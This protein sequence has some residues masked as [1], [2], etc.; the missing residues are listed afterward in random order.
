[1]SAPSPNNRIR[2]RA[3]RVAAR[4][5]YDNLIEKT[6]RALYED[7]GFKKAGLVLVAALFVSIICCAWDVP[8]P[9]KLGVRNE[10]NIVC[11]TPFRVHSPDLTQAERNEVR[12]KTLPYYVNDP[13]KLDDYEGELINGLA[14]VLEESDFSNCSEGS[15]KFL[16]GFLSPKSPENALA[17][18]FEVLRSYFA[19]DEGLLQFRATLEEAFKPYREKGVL[20]SLRT[21][22]DVDQNDDVVNKTIYIK[23]YEKGSDPK[24]AR[25][26]QASEALLGSG[27]NV[28]TILKERIDNLEVVAYLSNKIKNTVPDTL[29]YDVVETD[30]ARDR[31]ELEVENRYLDFEPG[32]TLVQAGRVLDEESLRLLSAEHAEL[33]KQRPWHA[34][35]LRFLA[36]DSLF[37]F[38]TIGAFILFRNKALVT[39]S[40]PVSSQTLAQI[41]SFLAVM[42]A[43]I[44]IGRVLQVL[45]PTGEP[46][47]EIAPF[48]VFVQ[49][50]AIA[51]TWE[52][53]VAFGTIVALTLNYSGC[54]GINE[55]I[56]FVGTGAIVSLASRNVRT[57]TQLFA[58][59]LCAALAG[60]MFT[61]IVEYAN[62]TFSD[63]VLAAGVC[64]LWCFFAGFFT[65]G[66]LPLFERLFGI[67]TPMRLLEYSNPSHPLLLELNRRAPA[68]YSHSIQTAALAEPA[69]E[70]IGARS[71]LI[72]VGAYFHD[73]GKMLQPEHFTE[74]QKDYNIHD[75]LEPRMSAL[76][77]V[78]HT[79][80]GVDLGKRYRLPKQI[81]DLIEQ[82]HGSMLVSFF[83]KKA[84]AAAQ[85][86]D[87]D[88][89]ALDE[90][91]FR[92]PGPIPQTKE[93]AILMLA[94]AVESASR[95]L[96]EWTPRRVENLVRK[97]S[98][99]RIEDGQFND[100]GLTLGEIHIV[101]QS[102]VSTLL[103]S[104]HTRVK[105]PDKDYNKPTDKAEQKE[106]KEVKDRRDG[107]SSEG[108]TVLAPTDQSGI[109]RAN[110]GFQNAS[111]K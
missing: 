3:Q 12:L 70:A 64:A 94:D 50:T 82:H 92:Y 104:K 13:S 8:I 95:S 58:V 66:I 85:E 27:Y 84:V 4:V 105:Y 99:A 35:A 38:L 108:T 69:A 17:Q 24:T 52:I 26:E 28:K 43:F 30:K 75:D 45:P 101:E 68:T 34:R 31:N 73:V 51:T 39:R 60:F 90:A 32:D 49:L 77:I 111:E 7:D 59:A 55:F 63:V 48:L 37:F 110:F 9:Y 5:S 97:L 106:N 16:K 103:A 42:V 78:A 15:Q 18:V 33:M 2:T 25:Q 79:K 53:A 46:L 19:E 107:S 67:L 102:L 76:V 41:G 29:D 91:P 62:D 22:Q 14:L 72:R 40:G 20:R 56:V 1:M 57:R 65:A 98:E 21:A 88:A 61:L 83:Y 47:R 10:R 74:N 44:G 96:P 100:S 36:F 80:D 81:V 86:K 87:P 23:V 93:A 11:Q 89:P 6:S 71:A 54:S 109:V